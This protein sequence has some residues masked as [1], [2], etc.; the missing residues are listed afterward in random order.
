MGEV[1]AFNADQV[2]RFT[3]LSRQQLRS[4]VRTGFFFPEYAD[5]GQNQLG[6]IY[7]FRDVVSLRVLARLHTEHGISLQELRTAGAS[8]RQRFRDPWMTLTF[9]VAGGHL[10]FDAPATGAKTLARG[11]AQLAL[12]LD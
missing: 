5:E 1:T 8:L 10:Y 7:S 2:S 3:G 4:W 11:A 6:Y 12:P 9:Y